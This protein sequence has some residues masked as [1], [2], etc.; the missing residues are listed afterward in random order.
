MGDRK[1]RGGA[2]H[3]GHNFGEEL[4]LLLLRKSGFKRS[5]NALAPY[6]EWKRQD[7][8]EAAEGIRRG[9]EDVKAGNTRPA[10]EYLADM[11]RKHDHVE[12]TAEAER[13]TPESGRAAIY[14][15]VLVP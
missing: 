15:R 2:Q 8:A 6:L 11:R 10:A 5:A 7:F 9:H 4:T 3:L 14:G 12:V 1:K 13:D